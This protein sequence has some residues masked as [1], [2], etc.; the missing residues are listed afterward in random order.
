MLVVRL[1]GGG[2]IC[3][4]FMNYSLNI[5]NILLN[6]FFN[7]RWQVKFRRGSNKKNRSAS[8]K[9]GGFYEKARRKKILAPAAK[10]EKIWGANFNNAP[11]GSKIIPRGFFNLAF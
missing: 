11:A 4:L 2:L 6:I 5:F 8:K 1:G 9:V 7:L 3:K 10:K